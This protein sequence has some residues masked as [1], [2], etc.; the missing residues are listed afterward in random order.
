M[1]NGFLDVKEPQNAVLPQ[2]PKPFPEST[3]RTTKL[4]EELVVA[5]IPYMRA[6]SL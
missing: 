4:Q 3:V 1:N 6:S 2:Q 5:E